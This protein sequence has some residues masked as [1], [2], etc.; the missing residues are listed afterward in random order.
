MPSRPYTGRALA[1]PARVGSL[2]GN[3]P[4]Q[5][6]ATL[7]AIVIVNETGIRIKNSNA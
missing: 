4:P 7:Y 3:Q 2:M 6:G 1:P 5:G